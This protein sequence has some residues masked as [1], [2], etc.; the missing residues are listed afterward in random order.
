MSIE[1]PGPSET[2]DNSG[3]AVEQQPFHKRKLSKK[4]VSIWIAV[5]LVLSGFGI[6]FGL[7]LAS[8][9]RQDT[10][11]RRLLLVQSNYPVMS[12]EL[13]EETKGSDD[14]VNIMV[15]GT[16]ETHS[17]VLLSEEHL[18]NRATI[19]CDDNYMIEGSRPV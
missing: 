9:M 18:K 15:K 5:S 10:L 7:S 2:A 6:I 8:D 13:D 17:C 4:F 14:Y 16:G 11:E 3:V 19:F 1:N 12:V